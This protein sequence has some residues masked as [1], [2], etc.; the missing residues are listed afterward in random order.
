VAVKVVHVSDLSGKQADEGD[1]GKLIVH[2][3]P[4]HD[5]PITLE[6]LPDEIGE[7]PE[8]EAYVRIEY[9]EPG[10]TTG[11]RAILS[12]E[13]F[14][15]LASSGDMNAILMEAVAER[16]GRSQQAVPR[17]PR[18]AGRT[19]SRGKVNYATLEHAGEPHRGRITEAEKELVRGNLDKINKRLRDAGLREIDPKDPEMQRRYGLG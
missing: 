19:V 1:F 2:E 12:V 3:H 10:S 8:D 17:R 9:V 4:K 7:L 13:R 6:V 16:Q 15:K 5:G 11:Q 14:N 18:A